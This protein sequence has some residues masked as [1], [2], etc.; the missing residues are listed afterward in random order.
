M[1]ADHARGEMVEATRAVVA[2]ARA[3]GVVVEPIL[4]EFGLTPAVLADP[5]QRLAID[6]TDGLW[7]RLVQASGDPDLPLRAVEHSPFGTFQVIDFLGAN[8]PTVGGGIAA[9][10][11]YFHI[12]HPHLSLTVDP[13]GPPWRVEA[14]SQVWEGASFTLAMVLRRFHTLAGP[15]VPNR[16][17]VTR[18][19][20]RDPELATR[21]FGPHIE[22]RADADVAWLDD[23]T[24]RRPM[25]NADPALLPLLHAHA[26]QAAG[27]P[28][29]DLEGQVVAITRQLLPSGR[30][31]AD[32]VA[33][34]LGLSRRTLQRRLGEVGTAFSTLL[35]QVRRD[36]ATRLLADPSLSLV[37][38]ALL[39]GY[40]DETAFQRAFRRW[41]GT[42]PGR[43]RRAHAG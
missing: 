18:A 33:A 40:A 19:P 24:W 32:H 11:R 36:R 3:A 6:G 12:I 7:A 29:S 21:L 22:W 39:L 5:S 30:A 35:A 14:R 34:R 28:P 4:A 25:P 16:V 38:V 8:S 15:C 17:R 23:A 13:A 37:E 27:P 31:D 9:L 26:R 20:T 1:A 43:W 2:A 10:T 41:F 42:S